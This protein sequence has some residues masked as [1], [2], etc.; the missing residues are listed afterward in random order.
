MFWSTELNMWRRKS[1]S[2]DQQTEW[3]DQK[4]TGKDIIQLYSN[5]STARK[6]RNRKITE[7]QKKA[8]RKDYSI[9]QS[10]EAKARI[11]M[12]KNSQAKAGY[13]IMKLPPIGSPEKPRK[14]VRR[15]SKRSSMKDEE[16]HFLPEINTLTSNAVYLQESRL[17]DP[18][19]D[20]RFQGLISCLLINKDYYG[21]L[22]R[23]APPK[24]EM[25]KRTRLG[26]GF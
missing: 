18:S 9:N 11:E 7:I 20:P 16:G 12:R 10:L 23:F 13:T 8:K 6:E 1:S 26:L 14:G 3:K 4:E 5:E 21:D 19:R 25:S 17:K 22:Q 24:G 2:K 15:W